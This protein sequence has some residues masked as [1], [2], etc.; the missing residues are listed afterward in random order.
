M[1]SKEQGLIIR[2]SGGFYYVET[3]TDI[4]ETR[5]RGIFRKEGNSPMVGD[6]VEIERTEEGK[7]VLTAI[8]PRKNHLIRPPVAN[9]DV[10]VMVVAT[11][12]PIPNLQVIDKLLA[13][14]I[15]KGIE[16]ILV[17]T[18]ADLSDPSAVVEIYRKAGFTVLVS[19]PNCPPPELLPLLAGKLAVFSGNTG[20]G[21][22]T[23][24]N[25]IA[26]G[27][28]LETGE[29]SKK[30]GRG[31][32]TTRTTGIFRVGEALI[33]DTPGFSSLETVMLEV[34]LKD[35]LADCFIEFR[36]YAGE[37]RFTG[38]SHTKE[39]GC[40]IIEAVEAQ[41]IAPSRFESYCSMYEDAK[42]LKEWDLPK[43]GGR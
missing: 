36:P 22:S 13:V 1:N 21:K 42:Q 25:S 26:P 18:K 40:R 2:L 35:E 30:L 31:R 16:P 23:L 12:S 39:K 6:Q 3:A 43:K 7:G 11:E 32:H 14:A 17:V 19:E 27:L 41:E 10:L 9:I 15:Y 28:A 8:L 5:A 29:V 33:A 34:I 4:V 24:L 37:C 20:V 38:C